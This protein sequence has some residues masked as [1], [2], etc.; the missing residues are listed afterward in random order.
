MKY[1][2]KEA[3]FFSEG[4]EVAVK[5]EF[6]L[7]VGYLA[8]GHGD[9]KEEF[10][11]LRKDSFYVFLDVEK[12]PIM[13]IAVKKRGIKN[14]QGYAYEIYDYKRQETIE[15]ADVKWAIYLYFHIKGKFNDVKFEA[16]EDWDEKIKLRK[17]KDIYAKIDVNQLTGK[18][19]I[20]VDEIDDNSYL[21]EISF[22]TLIYCMNRIY[23]ME[24]EVVSEIID[25]FTD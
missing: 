25:A 16:H 12:A 3:L 15:L 20:E 4:K 10:I 5:N 2:F 13:S 7:C 24:S 6:G 17:N 14:L 19:S 8:R 23:K 22:I 18:V 1:S 21:T 9:I 11:E